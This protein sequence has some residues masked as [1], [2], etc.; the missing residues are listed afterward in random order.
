MFYKYGFD[1]EGKKFIKDNPLEFALVLAEK[2]KDFPEYSTGFLKAKN[3]SGN[4]VLLNPIVYNKKTLTYVTKDGERALSKYFINSLLKDS[5][6]LTDMDLIPADISHLKINVVA[7]N[8]IENLLADF[9]NIKVR[10][11]VVDKQGH[12][13][14]LKIVSNADDSIAASLIVDTLFLYDGKE[15]I[16][17][18]K[19]KYTKKEF[20]KAFYDDTNCS[21]AKSDKAFINLATIDYSRLEE[22]YQNKGLGYVMYFHMAQYLESEGV[23]F[24]SSTLQSPL[25]KRLWDGINKNWGEH[26]INKKFYNKHCSFLKMGKELELYFEDNL[27]KVK[28]IKIT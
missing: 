26:I 3:K 28:K 19:V 8:K 10:K 5:P 15:K 16:G 20:I 4:E 12:K 1:S 17:H 27:P 2:F 25:A 22:K 11:E 7:K 21:E 6:E 23:K 14:N 9:F 18:V 24:R 13:Y